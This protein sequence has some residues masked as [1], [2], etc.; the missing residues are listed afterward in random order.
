MIGPPELSEAAPYYFRYIDRIADG[1]IIGVLETQLEEMS[2]L[3][4]GISEEKSLHRYAPEKW[5]IRQVVNHVNDTERVFVSRA[6]WFARGF[7][8]PLPSYDQEI[9]TAAAR[10]DEFSWASHVEEF[11]GVRL[12][13]LAFFRNLPAGAWMRNGIASGNP[14]SV[15]ALAYI[16]AGHAS[17][18]TAILRDRYL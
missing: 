6:F 14:F 16:T 15:R 2:V 12:A 7:D 10:A 3:L 9:S 18:H 5:S 1:D 17:H 8:S 13:T 11:R 4:L